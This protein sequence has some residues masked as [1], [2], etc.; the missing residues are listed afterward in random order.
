[1]L[2][3]KKAFFIGLLIAP[4]L[5]LG[6]LGGLGAA[7]SQNITPTKDVL[8]DFLQPY[9]NSPPN[10][11]QPSAGP[12]C[13]SRVM[14]IVAHQDDDILF[15]NPDLA[16]GLNLGGCV[17][18]IYM[19]A[20]DAGQDTSYWTQREHGA[21][22]AYSSMLKQ[23]LEWQEN[24]VKIANRW[25]VNTATAKQAPNV[26]LVFVR[27]PDGD[28]FGEGFTSNNLE[29]LER[30]QSGQISAL[31][32]VDG[33]TSYSLSDLSSLLSGLIKQYQP[34][35]IR[36]Q[37]D[38][39]PDHSDHIAVSRLVGQAYQQFVSENITTKSTSLSLYNGYQIGS[40]TMNVSGEDLAQKENAFLEYSKYDSAVCSNLEECYYASAYGLYF[41]RQYYSTL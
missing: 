28:L 17:Q 18:T 33:Q 22:A 36:T 38:D 23:S 37:A 30:L 5:C 9:I 4:V 21:E 39:Y 26:S 7:Q 13:Q 1:M 8:A 15:M 12:V 2:T 25:L 6:L 31:Q 11:T 10:I 3:N 27:L 16:R 34:D 20:G 24:Q 40:M 41:T 32:T 29:S 14:N 35:Q 19:T